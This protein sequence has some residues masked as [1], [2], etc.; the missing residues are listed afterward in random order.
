MILFSCCFGL[1]LER[2]VSLRRKKKPV[3]SENCTS[4]K[5]K[6]EKTAE[7]DHPMSLKNLNATDWAKRAK[8]I[9]TFSFQFVFFNVLNLKK[10]DRCGSEGNS[11]NFQRIWLVRRTLN[12][13]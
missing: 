11:T 2:E 3:H 12:L 7:R 5:K 9:K 1:N 6:R 8:R 10:K 13:K 4:A